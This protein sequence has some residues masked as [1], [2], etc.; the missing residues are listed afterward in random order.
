[1]KQKPLECISKRKRW[2][3]FVPASEPQQG[4]RKFNGRQIAVCP[5]LVPYQD[6][7]AAR[8]PGKG[9]LYHPAAGGVGLLALH[10]EFF[11]ADAPDVGHIARF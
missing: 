2:V 6:R 10:V 7:T 5:L 3:K 11:L 1:M 4:T 8:Q 9:A